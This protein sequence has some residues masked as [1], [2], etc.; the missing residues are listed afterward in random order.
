MRRPLF[1]RRPSPGTVIALIALFVAIGGT[2]FA[3][4]APP[5]ALSP[6]VPHA[7]FA[8]VANSARI[9][10]VHYVTADR[11]LPDP[12]NENGPRPVGTQAHC[13]G[14]E[15]VIGGG[16]EVS[17]PEGSVAV[18]SGPRGEFAWGA[19]GFVFL[20]SGQGSQ[21]TVTAIC[22]EAASSKSDL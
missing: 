22:A 7:T 19:Y 6:P 12:S 16:A 2:S 5:E 4:T 21:L 11:R 3:F 13:P 9:S 8:D 1:T 10:F 20:E 18:D 17:K 14:G 15:K